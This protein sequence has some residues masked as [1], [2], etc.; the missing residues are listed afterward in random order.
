MILY[1]VNKGV[2]TVLS[3]LRETPAGWRQHNNG[4]INRSNLS[5][6]HPSLS[7]W[8]YTTDA[9][10]AIRWARIQMQL[11]ADT[12]QAAQASLDDVINWKDNGSDE[13]HLPTPRD[14]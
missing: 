12:L 3:V 10:K 2:V 4:F 11:M 9:D 7:H 5:E 1:K 14:I 8:Y 6:Q 13:E